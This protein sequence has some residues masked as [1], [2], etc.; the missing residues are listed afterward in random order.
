MMHC[1][2]Q[3]L[4]LLRYGGFILSCSLLALFCW[5]NIWSFQVFFSFL[6]LAENPVSKQEQKSR[7]Q[8]LSLTACEV[9]ASWSLISDFK[10]ILQLNLWQISTFFQEI[11]VHRSWVTSQPL[12]S[13]PHYRQLSECPRQNFNRFKVV[14]S[15]EQSGE[16]TDYS[17][18]G[19]KKKNT[20]YDTVR[21]I[22]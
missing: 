8:L 6:E 13:N 16:A 15:S 5:H 21:Y 14:I 22:W 19:K 18:G 17:S 7:L 12:M 4:P 2:H 1:I 11:P 20:I 10:R 3:K 9:Y